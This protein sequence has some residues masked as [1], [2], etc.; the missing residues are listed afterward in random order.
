MTLNVHVN[1]GIT[2]FCQC[3]TCL[4]HFDLVTNSH[5]RYRNREPTLIFCNR[6]IYHMQNLLFNWCVII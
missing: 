5:T 3:A 6:M 1:F 4:R 2:P